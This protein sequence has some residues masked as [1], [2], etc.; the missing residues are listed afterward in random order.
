MNMM[1]FLNL[2]IDLSVAGLLIAVIAYSKKL[3]RSI[4]TLQDSRSEMA[5]LFAEFDTS[6]E[7]AQSSV[8]E[9][10][11]ATRKSEDILRDK[12]ETANSLADDLAFMIERGNKTADQIES[13]LKGGRA[14]KNEEP[15]AA[16]A[17]ARE[18]RDADKELE[19]L[20]KPPI[21]GHKLPGRSKESGNAARTASIESVL[22]QMAN[23]NNPGAKTA[24]GKAHSRIRSKAEQ[25]LFDSLK[26]GR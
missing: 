20:G 2:L 19:R 6:I 11:D 26:S 25:E 18:G 16:P 24:D 14:L 5:K 13:G 10:K 17:Q 7:A 12:L 1:P 3:S 9:L 22:E 8:R 21:G 15:A 23:R 4:K